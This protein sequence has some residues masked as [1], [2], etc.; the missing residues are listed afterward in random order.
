MKFKASIVAFALIFSMLLTG[1][2]VIGYASEIMASERQTAKAATTITVGEMADFL[3]AKN[4]HYPFSDQF[5]ERYQQT[6][7]G[8]LDNAKK[9][10]IPVDRQSHSPNQKWHFFNSWYYPSIEEGTLSRDDDAKNRI[11]TKLLCP[12]LLL[13]IY[14]ACGV[15]P[16]KVKK[17]MDAAAAGKAAGKAVTSI[18]KDMRNCVAWEDLAAALSVKVPAESVSLSKSELEIEVGKSASVT[19]TVS[20][21]NATDT[22]SFTIT[23]GEDVVSITKKANEVSVLG[24]KEGT[25]KISVSYNKNVTAEFSVT[26]IKNDSPEPEPTPS[27][28]GCVYNVVYDLGARKTA[29]PL[30]TLEEVF[31]AL[32][33]FGDGNG[34]I[35]AVTEKA[36]I[37]GGGN[38]GSGDAKWYTGNLLKVGTTSKLGSITLN[39]SATVN[40]VKIT[41]YVHNTSAKI[42]VGGTEISGA[43]MTVAGK[44]SIEAGQAST[45]LITFSAT[46]TLTIETTAKAPL[47]IT[48]IELGYDESLEN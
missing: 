13:W 11:Y 21:I 7:G 37:A 5:T 32:T 19:A 16:E 8:Y 9:A 3:S 12:E 48:S 22:A 44:E 43:D 42:S 46:G 36:N 24:L 17:A 41:G 27:T 20:P 38:G 39:L 6:S 47:Y 31:D 25:A 26:V 14:E 18:A 15:A 2:S 30:E 35:T 4:E 1:T 34:I 28:D 40:Y 29:K 23:E 33:L 45:V 10:D